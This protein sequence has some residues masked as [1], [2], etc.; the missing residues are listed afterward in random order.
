[1]SKPD[2]KHLFLLAI[3]IVALCIGA[4]A[5]GDNGEIPARKVGFTPE[6]EPEKAPL[7]PDDSN[8]L[9]KAPAI[10]Q[11][12]LEGQPEASEPE[13]LPPAAPTGFQL[14]SRVLRVPLSFARVTPEDSPEMP[15]P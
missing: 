6:V 12:H 5:H 2:P 9:V 14:I 11:R 7:D 3:A 15:S 10:Q 4:Y 8:D 13:P 1:M